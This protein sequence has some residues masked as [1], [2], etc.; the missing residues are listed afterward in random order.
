MWRSACLDAT[1]EVMDQIDSP[2]PDPEAGFISAP[3]L[4]LLAV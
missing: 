4:R 3:T 2:C 1:W